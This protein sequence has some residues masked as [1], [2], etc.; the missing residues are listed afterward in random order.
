MNP[1]TYRPPPPP[2]H[3]PDDL[4]GLMVRGDEVR[5]ESHRLIEKLRD[6]EDEQLAIRIQ[7]RAT[8]SSTT[9]GEQ[10]DEKEG[11]SDRRRAHN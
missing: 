1:H 9:R 6:M 11:E 10:P 7:M 8:G 4:A 2:P 3:L 5:A